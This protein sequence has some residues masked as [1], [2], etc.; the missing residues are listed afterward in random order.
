MVCKRRSESLGKLHLGKI[1][2]LSLSILMIFLHAKRSLIRP[3]KNR[4]A[5][6]FCDIRLG[7]FNL[8]KRKA[9][10][11]VKYTIF[12]VNVQ[13]TLSELLRVNQ[14]EFVWPREKK[15]FKISLLEGASG[16]ACSGSTQSV[17]LLSS[18]NFNQ[19]A[20]RHKYLFRSF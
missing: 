18:I 5:K 17:S 1:E 12:N 15:L 3:V 13:R 16:N 4:A 11:P 19:S 9:L 14:P 6:Q 2:V 10:M 20:N 8:Y 7:Y